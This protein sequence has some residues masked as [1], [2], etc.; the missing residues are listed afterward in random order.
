VRRRSNS[1]YA[2]IC[3]QLLAAGGPLKV[4]QIW[5]GM[6]ATGFQHR[7]VLPRSTLG[8][9]IAELVRMKKLERVGRATYRLLSEP[10]SELSSEVS[11]EVSP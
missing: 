5:Q 1:W 2:A 9:R 7:S 3:A 10:S 4:D 6:E 8:G 11:S